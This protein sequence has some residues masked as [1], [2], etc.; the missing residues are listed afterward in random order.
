MLRKKKNE[1][2]FVY[3]YHIFFIKKDT[4]YFYLFR[5]YAGIIDSARSHFI[6]MFEKGREVRRD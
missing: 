3:A 1:K 5:Q 2:R 6:F 4:E